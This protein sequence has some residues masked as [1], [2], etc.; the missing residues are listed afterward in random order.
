MT[1]L[2]EQVKMQGHPM[3]LQTCAHLKDAGT[4]SQKENDRK[5]T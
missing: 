4:A 2:M 3:H 1:A 5:K